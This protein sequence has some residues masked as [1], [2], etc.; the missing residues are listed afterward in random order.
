[1]Q[2]GERHLARAGQEQLVVGEPVDLLLGV[3]QQAGAE[4]RLLA[5][6]HRR[7]DRLEALL[8]ERRR[9]PSAPA[10]ARAARGRRAGRRSASR[11]RARPPPCRSARR[12]ARGGPG[13]PR[14]RAR[15]P[16]A[17]LGV[18]VGG[19][20]V[21]RVG[22]RGERGLQLGVDPRELLAQRPHARRDAPASRRS[23]PPRRRPPSSPRR[24]P[25]TPRSGGRAAPPPRAAAR[26]G[27]R[28]AR[29]PRRAARRTRRRRRASA[30]RTG[31][32]SR[33]IA[34]RS[35]TRYPG[36]QADRRVAVRVRGR[37]A[38]CP[39]TWRRSPRPS[40]PPP[41]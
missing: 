5:H 41:R 11:P 13:R 32:G 7:H 38:P 39:S 1:M 19:G 16:R 34:L 14:A 2:R 25:A 8:A 3:G 30:A 27:A 28:R 33:R 24:S 26:A 29:A 37:L 23:P 17:D 31:S 20:R 12:P 15:R 21:R 22:Q 9:A 6:E 35:S 40:A 36:G 4:Q 10:R 18:G